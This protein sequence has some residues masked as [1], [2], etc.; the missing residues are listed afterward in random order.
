MKKSVMRER[1]ANLLLWIG[2]GISPIPSKARVSTK[3]EVSIGRTNSQRA[4]GFIVREGD[5]SMDFVLDRNQVDDLISYLRMSRHRLRKPLGRRTNGFYRF[6][7][8]E[9]DKQSDAAEAHS[10][11][12]R[13]NPR[14]ETA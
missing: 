12:S 6:F 11:R 13:R 9:F 3:T 4:L 14:A 8:E 1:P 10:K 2:D 5:T 7:F